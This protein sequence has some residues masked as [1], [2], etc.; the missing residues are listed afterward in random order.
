[1]T[2]E[3]TTI[4]KKLL[5]YLRDYLKTPD[6]EYAE[7]LTQLKGG[8]ETSIYRFRLNAAPKDV[9]GSLVL[10]LYPAYYG[11]GNAVWE[12]V[13]QTALAGAEYPVARSHGI[14]KDPD[15][16]GGAFF[17]MDFMPGHL[18]VMEP[19]ERIPG[20]LGLAQA[21]LHKMAPEPLMEAMLAAG[22]EEQQLYASRRTDWLVSKSET[23]PWVREAADWLLEHTLPDPDEWVVCHGDFHPL[24]ILVQD[25]VVT[26]VLD[27]AGFAIADPALDVGNTLVL[28]SVPFKHIGPQLGIQVP[29]EALE[30]FEE[31]FLAAYQAE[32]PLDHSRLDYYRVRRC[33]HALI[34]GAEGQ[35][36]WQYPPIVSDL[37]TMIKDLTGV[38]VDMP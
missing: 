33:V 36:I 2:P 8:F 27:W 6:L 7:P 5:A 38:T 1:M 28:A 3:T 20:M 25:G 37:I 22:F 23:Y 9:S 10:R 12:S 32:L 17:I 30:T 19:F 18:M 15:V 34:E 24:N 13:I 14:C 29:Q 4:A 16:L 35:E 11:S 26:G 21:E 31:P